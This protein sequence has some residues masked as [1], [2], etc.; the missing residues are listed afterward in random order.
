MSKMV[1][2]EIYWIVGRGTVA[3][4]TPDSPPKTGP[5][6][7][8]N[9]DGSYIETELVGIEGGRNNVG[10]VLRGVKKD[11]IKPG[12]VILFTPDLRSRT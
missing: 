1:V 10:L 3:C 9:P 8:T 6:S 5:A 4:G 12:A 7:I 2:E 11:E